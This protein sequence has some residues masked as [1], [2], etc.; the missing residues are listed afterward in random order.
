MT[1]LEVRRGLWSAQLVLRHVEDKKLSSRCNC[2]ICDADLGT[3]VSGS[4]LNWIPSGRTYILYGACGE[5]LDRVRA[6]LQDFV[7]SRKDVPI[8]NAGTLS[9]R[10]SLAKRIKQYGAN[11]YWF[12]GKKSS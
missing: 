12:P 10:V 2:A 3:K 9:L 8:T 4:S 6:I 7:N 11:S 1:F 5:H